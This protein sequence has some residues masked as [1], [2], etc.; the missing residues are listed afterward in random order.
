L[1]DY[2]PPKDESPQH[3]EDKTCKD[4]ARFNE[5]RLQI[6]RRGHHSQ[7]T[8]QPSRFTLTLDKKKD[9][10]DQGIERI[11]YYVDPLRKQGT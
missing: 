2:I 8:Y 1:S 11:L 9:L 4:C 5:C 3:P 7:C 6:N 10:L